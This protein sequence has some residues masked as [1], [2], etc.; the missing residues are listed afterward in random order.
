MTGRRALRIEK[1]RFT[2]R[3]GVTSEGCPIAKWVIRRSNQEEKYCVIV[4]NRYGHQC[5]YAWIAVSLIQWDGLPQDLA[6]AAY[7]QMAQKTAKYGSETERMCGA[8]KKKTC[9]CQ[10]VNSSF[11]GASYTFGCSWTMYQNVCKFCR[12]SEA[13]K[14][15]LKDGTEEINLDL[16]CQKLT[17]SVTPSF[18][19]LAPDCY[20]N[21]CLFEEVAGDCRIGTKPGRPFSGITTVCDY[22]AH[23]HK[24]NNN[25]IGGCTV[26]VT[27][28]R[29]ENRTLAKVD[30]EQF[31]VL[32]QYVPDVTP[33]EVQEKVASGG[34][35]VLSKFQR[36]ITVR[37][38][39][40]KPN[41]KRGRPTAE[42]K[43]ML[44]GYVPDGYTDEKKWD[45]PKGRGRSLSG[46][47][48][49]RSPKGRGV[50][51]SQSLSNSDSEVTPRTFKIKKPKEIWTTSQNKIIS[52]Q[53]KIIKLPAARPATNIIQNYSAS[54]ST[55]N[56]MNNLDSLDLDY[57][58]S[59][60]TGNQ[61]NPSFKN[62]LFPSNNWNTNTARVLPAKS[63]IKPN[64]QHQPAYT[65]QNNR[66][67]QISR[68][69][70]YQPSSNYNSSNPQ[71]SSIIRSAQKFTRPN[72]AQSQISQNSYF[73]D[74]S[75]GQPEQR[76]VLPANISQMNSGLQQQPRKIVISNPVIYRPQAA[77]PYIPRIPNI[78]TTQRPTDVSKTFISNI[79]AQFDDSILDLLD[80]PIEHVQSENQQEHSASLIYANYLNNLPQV[81]GT[82]DLDPEQIYAS[83]TNRLT[84]QNNYTAPSYTPQTDQNKQLYYGTN[85]E[86]PAPNYYP[87][88]SPSSAPSHINTAQNLHTRMPQQRYMQPQNIHNNAMY[89]ST[90]NGNF[91]QQPSQ[92][93]HRPQTRAP[94]PRYTSINRS[95]P[96]QQVH[97]PQ[98]L[99]PPPRYN[100]I[101]RSQ[102]AQPTPRFTNSAQIRPRP[103]N[104][105]R[106]APSL[107]QLQEQTEA[108][109]M[110]S[111]P[112]LTPIQRFSTSPA[113][114]NMT[115]HQS[116]NL[117]QFQVSSFS[118]KLEESQPNQGGANFS[119]SYEQFLSDRPT[120]SGSSRPISIS[121]VIS[122]NAPSRTTSISSLYSGVQQNSSHIIKL[123]DNFKKDEK[124]DNSLR[125]FIVQTEVKSKEIDPCEEVK[126][127]KPSITKYESDCIEAFQ[128]ASIGGIALALPHGSI[129]VEVAKHELHATTALKNPN[130]FNP[131]RIGLVFYQH[132]NL[133]YANHGA[134]E[135]LKKNLIREHRDY[136]QWLKGCFVPSPTKLGTMQKS[137]FCFPENVI[138][139][140]PSQESKPEDRFHPSAYPGFVPGKYV[141]GKFVKIDVDE[142]HSYEIFKSKLTSKITNGS[143]EQGFYTQSVMNTSSSSDFIGQSLL[144]NSEQSLTT[145]P[146]NF[147]SE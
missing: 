39:P 2:G 118:R 30:D 5:E 130:R 74:Q 112:P 133:H 81:D 142:D 89:H 116:S 31:H 88:A 48:A 71:N 127:E 145:S 108:E 33:E 63:V 11:N 120:P 19:R 92:Q 10:G 54:N 29:P 64:S 41:C 105:I 106:T 37:E 67:I 49:S 7:E 8:N 24:D 109:L 57:S 75:Y 146:F 128:D 101:N 80:E 53:Q 124:P 46:S 66:N 91:A 44:D 36:T 95:V 18:E 119:S 144:N 16:I 6:D 60:Q 125:D 140:K 38:K 26:V 94:P 45:S 23:S 79:E 69:N 93:I 65:I 99:Q 129:L 59:N 76:H 123:E 25:M 115:S 78:Q 50:S 21:M 141:D 42:K 100:S 22:C 104:H 28:T 84:Q 12:S 147:Y 40:T 137:G 97:H 17:D 110:Q 86:A 52:S 34:L 143:E 103:S 56:D 107:H 3:E 73:P 122:D 83:Y 72:S 96:L 35:E 1:V 14:F 61:S 82:S 126:E 138:T 62:Q 90:N 47:P 77:Q 85:S 70:T 13:R 121:P 134:D 117:N 15:R 27:L 43:K 139:I 55:L 131:C 20:N 9:A 4:K 102:F 135:F 132:K 136:I 113:M 87:R 111:I 114:Q 98:N 32:P 68:P 51:P 58:Y